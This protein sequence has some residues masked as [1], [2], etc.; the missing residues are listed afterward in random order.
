MLLPLGWTTQG[1]MI[2]VNPLTAVGGAG[3]SIAAKIDFSMMRE[4]YAHVFIRWLPTINYAQPS[5][6]PEPNQLLKESP[7]KLL[8]AR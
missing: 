8:Y 3:Q 7:Q 4:P 6:A 5:L 2:R 1:G